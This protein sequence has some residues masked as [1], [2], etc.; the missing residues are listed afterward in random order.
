M[1]SET[2]LEMQIKVYAAV[3]SRNEFRILTSDKNWLGDILINCRRNVGKHK[4]EKWKKFLVT[5]FWSGQEK[6][7]VFVN[8]PY[9]IFAGQLDAFQGTLKIV[10]LLI[11]LFSNLWP[12]DDVV[13]VVFGVERAVAFLPNWHS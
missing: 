11:S 7:N 2:S 8:C 1:Q 9:E 13:V 5:I 6:K 4:S 12:N 10:N 3:N